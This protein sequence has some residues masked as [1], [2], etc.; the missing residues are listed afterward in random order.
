MYQ[1]ERR[2]AISRA[3]AKETPNAFPVKRART[4]L[5][6]RMAARKMKGMT[7]AA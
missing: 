2:D 5:A 1:L 3:A 4:H 7:A 6:A